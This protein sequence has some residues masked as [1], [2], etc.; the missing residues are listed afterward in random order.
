MALAQELNLKGRIYAQYGWLDSALVKFDKAI[1]L[2]ES[3]LDPHIGKRQIYLSQGEYEK[4]LKESKLLLNRFEEK[5]VFTDRI[6]P[7]VILEFMG[8]SIQ[9]FHGYREYL[10]KIDQQLAQPVQGKQK[11]EH[12]MN[13]IFL[14]MLL[15]QKESALSAFKVFQKDNPGEQITWD[16]FSNFDKSN[17][18]VDMMNV[19]SS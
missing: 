2:D 8:D 16:F 12:E 1:A 18:I 6:Y 10:N 5:L 4:A 3:L 17:Y 11:F 15:E 13:R 19:G 7:S 14:L 9:A